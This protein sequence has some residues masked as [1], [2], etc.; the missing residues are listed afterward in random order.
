MSETRLN[1]VCQCGW[2]SGVAVDLWNPAEAVQKCPYCPQCQRP[3]TSFNVRLEKW[4]SIATW[5]K[6]WTW[7]IGYWEE[8]KG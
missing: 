2:R 3:T 5:Y 7:G 1:L 8:R 4:V 6:P